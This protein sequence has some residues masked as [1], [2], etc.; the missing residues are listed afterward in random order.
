MTYVVPHQFAHLHPSL[1]DSIRLLDTHKVVVV[2]L[3]VVV[4]RVFAAVTGTLMDKNFFALSASRW[5]AARF[6]RVPYILLGARACK[7]RVCKSVLCVGP[8]YGRWRSDFPSD[9]MF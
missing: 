8:T 9:R 7:V 6:L 3:V 1:S 5:G 4:V 2:I